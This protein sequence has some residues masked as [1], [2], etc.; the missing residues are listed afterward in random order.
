MFVIEHRS[1]PS[2]LPKDVGDLLE[3]LIARILF[4]PPFALRVIAVLADDKHGVHAQV[5]SST[6]QRLSHGRVD[7]ETKFPGALAAQVVLGK[8]IHVGRDN[9]EWWAMP[10]AAVGIADEEAFAHM[11]GMGVEAPFRRDDGHPFA[12]GGFASER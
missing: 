2:V 3:K 9:V 11:P 12:A 7:R 1:G 6:A 4:L 10:G 8:L 5:F